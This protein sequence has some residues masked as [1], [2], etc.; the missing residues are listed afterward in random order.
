[1]AG[2]KVR[3]YF[4]INLSSPRS[5]GVILWRYVTHLSIV[6][7]SAAYGWRSMVKLNKIGEYSSFLLMS[8]QTTTR[9][10]KQKLDP[11]GKLSEKLLSFQEILGNPKRALKSWGCQLF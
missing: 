10:T 8:P 11:R 1:V 2:K 6:V 5:F 4:S 9:A 7:F 3:G